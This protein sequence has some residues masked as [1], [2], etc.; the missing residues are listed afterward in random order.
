MRK[1]TGVVKLCWNEF[2][3]KANDANVIKSGGWVKLCGNNFQSKSNKK[4][5]KIVG[6]FIKLCWNE[7]LSKANNKNVIK[8][9]K[10]NQIILI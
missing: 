8:S 10:L 1:H 6:E 3:S 7:F 2:L 9:G 5:E 4:S